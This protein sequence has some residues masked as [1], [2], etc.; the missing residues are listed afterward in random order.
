MTKAQPFQFRTPQEHANA[1]RLTSEERAYL[2][3]QKT[4]WKRN[5]VG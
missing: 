2:E 3:A 1:V 4:A 5:E